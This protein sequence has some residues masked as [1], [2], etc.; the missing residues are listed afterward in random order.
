MKKIFFSF[1]LN[2]LVF[3]FVISFFPGVKF[4]TDI[5]YSFGIYSALSAGIM[6]QKPLLKFL[7]VK[8][9][10]LTYTLCAGI[11]SLGVFYLLIS[12][13]SGFVIIDSVIP[14]YNMG[15]I[16]INE[17]QLDKMM[18]IVFIVLLASLISGIMEGL[19]KPT[20]E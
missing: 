7:T 19:K 5:L 10:I 8:N 4:P 17:L 16:T 20:E 1:L 2:I 15:A 6:L 12:T 9:N 14:Q 11:I 13:I 3:S 18:T